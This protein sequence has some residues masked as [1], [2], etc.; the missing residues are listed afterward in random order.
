[1]SD[2]NTSVMSRWANCWRMPPGAGGF[3]RVRTSQLPLSTQARSTGQHTGALCEKAST[4]R[5]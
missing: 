2:V 3:K 5:D 4:M 1:M